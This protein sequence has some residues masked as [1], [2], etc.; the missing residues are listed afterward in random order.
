MKNILAE[1]MI[2]FG[3]K[4][5]NESDIKHR[6]TEALA[7]ASLTLNYDNGMLRFNQFFKGGDL[8]WDVNATFKGNENTMT[9]SEITFVPSYSAPEGTATVVVPLI[10]PF[11]FQVP[12][13]AAGGPGSSSAGWT[14][15]QNNWSAGIKLNLKSPE[16][17]KVLAVTDP[18]KGNATTM[19][20]LNM[21]MGANILDALYFYSGAKGWYIGPKK[22]VATVYAIFSNHNGESQ[23][24]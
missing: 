10:K 13:D 3:T 12:I 15:L 20:S 8:V 6:L 7:P 17:A 19:T 22:D 1:N 24:S 23:N 16:M 4:N 11:S 5:I 9:I 18:A 2:R 14:A 21:V